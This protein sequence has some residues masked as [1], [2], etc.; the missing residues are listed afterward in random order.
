M[1]NVPDKKLKDLFKE[2]CAIEMDD[3]LIEF[4]KKWKPKQPLQ[5]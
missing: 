4:I 1:A 5:K 2:K 3:A